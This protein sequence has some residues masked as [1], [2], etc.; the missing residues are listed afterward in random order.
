MHISEISRGSSISI[1]VT[2][3][4]KKFTFD[5]Q[6]KLVNNN[7]MLVPAIKYNHKTISF[8]ENFMIDIHYM[9]DGNLYRFPD[10]QLSLV[11]YGSSLFHKIS[12]EQEGTI[13][14]R[15][16]DYRLYIGKDMKLSIDKENYTESITVILKDISLSGFAFISKEAYKIGSNVYLKYHDENFYIEIPGNIVRLDFNEHLN[17]NTYGCTIAESFP[18]LGEY[19]IVKQ[20][21]ILR[22]ARIRNKAMK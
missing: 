1:V 2:F 7:I 9:K 6:V 4:D 21:E 5:S 12:V 15:R 17:C 13:Y 14:N 10:V 3:Q 20:R 18:K 11:R 19:L 16:G 8:N 22:K